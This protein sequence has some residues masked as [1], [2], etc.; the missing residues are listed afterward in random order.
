MALLEPSRLSPVVNGIPY[1]AIK[2]TIITQQ[3]LLVIFPVCRAITIIWYLSGKKKRKSVY[4]QPYPG[5]SQIENHGGLFDFILFF[6]VTPKLKITVDYLILLF[7]CFLGCLLPNTDEGTFGRVVMA[8]A[9]GITRHGCVVAVKTV[10]GEH[11]ACTM[12][13]AFSTYIQLI[14]HLSTSEEQAVL[15]VCVR[16]PLLPHIM[17]SHL[18]MI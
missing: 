18:S 14:V 8:K 10:K 2:S 4:I 15:G 12:S 6:R 17:N 1:L 9:Y 16:F 5:N 11:Y 3:D 7:S 13:V